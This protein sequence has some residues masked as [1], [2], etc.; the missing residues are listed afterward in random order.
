M[1]RRLS[2]NRMSLRS[3]RGPFRALSLSGILFAS[4]VGYQNCGSDFVAS[5]SASFASV[6]A[7]QCD[8]FLQAAFAQSFHPFLS[9]TCVGCHVPGG[10]GKGAFASSDPSV[11]YAA[12]VLDTPAEVEAR[13]V[14]PAHASGVTGPANQSAIASAKANWD[15]AAASCSA[16]SQPADSATVTIAKPVSGT[17]AVKTIT[18]KLDSELANGS[19]SYGGATFT[20]GIQEVTNVSGDTLYYFTSPTLKTGTV[21]LTAGNLTVQLNGVD[22]NLMTTFSQLNFSVPVNSTQNMCTTTGTDPFTFAA[23]DTV[24]IKFGILTKN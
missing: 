7:D 17:A 16:A 2:F 6:S 4:L 14:D 24:S 19:G 12:F 15:A 22:Q 3:P 10:I 23:S 20:V 13:A 1:S 9:T 5:D 11:S 18:W 8:S 21:A